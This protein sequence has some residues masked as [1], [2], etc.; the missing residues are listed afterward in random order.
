MLFLSS[1]CLARG[2][3]SLVVSGNKM[4]GTIPSNVIALASLEYRYVQL[5]PCEFDVITAVAALPLSVAS[6]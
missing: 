6:A 2:R 1:A 4:V 5:C 3:E